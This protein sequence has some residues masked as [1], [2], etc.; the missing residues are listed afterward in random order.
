[1]T[2]L[3]KKETMVQGAVLLVVVA[4]VAPFV[5]FAVP[6]AVGADASFVVLTGSMEPKIGTGD[7]VV[8]A[9][10]IPRNVERG[11][12]ITFLRPGEETPTTHRVVEVA[13][14]DGRTA[15]IT[16]GDNNEDVD[17]GFVTPGMLVGRVAF[18]LPFVGY[19]VQF[20]NTPLGAALFVVLPVGLFVASEL[21][22]YRKR[23]READD[24][25][26]PTDSSGD[27]ESD[28]GPTAV[29]TRSS[30]LTVSAG[31]LQWS[32]LV[33]GVAAAYA[34]TVTVLVYD[35]SVTYAQLLQVSTAGAVAFGVALVA[36]LA[37]RYLGEPVPDAPASPDS[38]AVAP[39]APRVVAG[40][41]DEATLALPRV[42]LGEAAELDRVAATLDRFVVADGGTR[43]VSDGETLYVHES[44]P[45]DVVPASA[46]V[47]ANEASVSEDATA[48]DEPAVD[49]EG[50]AGDE[51]FGAA[52]RVPVFDDDAVPGDAGDVEGHDAD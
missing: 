5:V 27:D 48:E 8:V 37:V 1:M 14:V 9:D 42:A 50:Q 34:T 20:A 33:L 41:L 30:G 35:G 3:P 7:A 23:R 39:D 11:D 19:V 43:Y 10:V 40:T 15:W 36:V 38:V 22:A 29:A 24:G 44:V 28:G 47:G 21:L 17:S 31:D 6:Q 26:G 25:A 49:P 12:V 2:Q 18:T 52:W 45:G 51:A 13:E 46:D 32:A 4:I 16:K